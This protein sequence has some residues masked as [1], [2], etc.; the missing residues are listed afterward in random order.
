MDSRMGKFLT[1][2]LG[3][4]RANQ[5]RGR[6]DR[7]RLIRSMRGPAKPFGV[8]QIETNSRCLLDVFC[9]SCR[10]KQRQHALDNRAIL[11]PWSWYV[12]VVSFLCC[13]CFSCS[14]DESNRG[15]PP[16]IRLCPVP[17]GVREQPST[18]RQGGF[19]STGWTRFVHTLSTVR[20]S[21]ALLASG[22]VQ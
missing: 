5:A 18:D 13:W 22:V 20:V 11:D 1:S 6:R 17:Q 10:R 7:T 3:P 16:R 14:V 15:C 2:M 8:W 4:S 12:F 19:R 9:F 21:R